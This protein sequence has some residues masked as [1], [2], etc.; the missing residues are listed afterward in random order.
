MTVFQKLFFLHNPV[1]FDIRKV[2]LETFKSILS[3]ELLNQ[4]NYFFLDTT[5][6]IARKPF[7]RTFHHGEM[8]PWLK[9]HSHGAPQ[10]LKQVGLGF[11]FP[12]YICL[13]LHRC[14]LKSFF[15]LFS[16][17]LFFFKY[18]VLNFS[19]KN[20]FFLIT[21]FRKPPSGQHFF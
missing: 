14:F 5:W 8:S 1:K 21:F 10:C 20:Y 7:L 9:W 3:E 12:G 18:P 11:S 17:L 15:F 19:F 6:Y 4:A 16:I 2:K 13:Q